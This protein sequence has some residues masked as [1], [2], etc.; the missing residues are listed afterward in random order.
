MAQLYRHA[1]GLKM[2]DLSRYLM[3]TGG[4]VTGLTDELERDGLVV[5]ESS[6]TDRRA[7]IVRLTPKGRRRFETH[8]ARTR[9]AGSSSCSPASTPPTCSQLYAQLGAAARA[10]GA[11]RR[12]PQDKRMTMTAARPIASIPALAAGNRRPPPATR[13]RISAGR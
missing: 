8:G 9:A 7:W 12:T 13:P 1:D 5:R 2:R 3:V 6:P 11:E 4:N 10:P